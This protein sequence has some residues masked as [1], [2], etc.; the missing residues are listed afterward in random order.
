MAGA[1]E[2][3]SQMWKQDNGWVSPSCKT[4]LKQQKPPG[5]TSRIL[6]Q[7]PLAVT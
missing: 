7:R 1:L 4:G 5:L 6:I 3:A 2:L